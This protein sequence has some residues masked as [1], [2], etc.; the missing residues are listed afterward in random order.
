MLLRNSGDPDAT[1]LALEKFEV[2]LAE[3]PN[4]VVTI[5]ALAHMLSRK[6]AYRR[7][8][9]LLEPLAAHGSRSTRQKTFPL[10]LKAYEA[11]GEVLKMAELRAK[12][13]SG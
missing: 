5:H 4:D 2:A 13:T 9:E 1:E 12:M 3:T 10:L 6:G 7:V 11:T 8:I